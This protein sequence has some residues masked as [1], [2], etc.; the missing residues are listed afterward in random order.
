MPIKPDEIQA[1]LFEQAPIRG[2]MT[3]VRESYQEIIQQRAYPPEVKRLLG[4]A[5]VAC[6]L[7]V[8]TL[9]FQGELALQFQGDDRLPLILI[10][11]DNQL[12]IRALAQFKPDESAESYANAFLQGQMVFTLTNA[13]KAQTYQTRLPIDTPSIAKNLMHYFAQSEQIPTFVWLAVDDEQAGGMLLQLMPDGSSETEQREVFWDYALHIGQTLTATE[14]FSLDNPTLLHRLY[15]E[16]DLR[17]FD[18]QSVRFQCRC[19]PEKMTQVLK[20]MGEA[21]C[22]SLLS[23]YKAVEAKCEFCLKTHRFDAIDIAT[24]FKK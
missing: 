19:T 14:L 18:P 22:Q 1:F 21:E 3:Y 11:C 13:Q 8:R 9:K 20:I 17:L 10:Q 4:E 23:T 5:M 6:L 24:V 2:Q 12:H 16:T 15:H 7:L